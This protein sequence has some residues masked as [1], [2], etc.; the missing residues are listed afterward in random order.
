MP[1]LKRLLK[2]ANLLIWRE[3]SGNLIL[4]R[5]DMMLHCG[6]TTYLSPPYV[7]MPPKTG[8]LVEVA[9]DNIKTSN[10]WSYQLWC[11]DSVMFYS[12]AGTNPVA[13]PGWRSPFAGALGLGRPGTVAKDLVQLW[14]KPKALFLLYHN[15]CLTLTCKKSTWPDENQTSQSRL[16]TLT[17]WAGI[18]WPTSQVEYFHCLLS[19]PSI[20][21]LMAF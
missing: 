10:E 3:C 12:R 13:T 7:L 6:K 15:V 9:C 4:Y 20:N 8:A 21:H 17:G 19:F 1:K 16:V 11:D 2:R 14:Q 18:F 5:G